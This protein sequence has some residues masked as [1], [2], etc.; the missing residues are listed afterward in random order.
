[1][2]NKSVLII[3]SAPNSINAKNWPKEKFDTIIVINNA[4]QIRS[5]WDYLIYPDDFPEER[6]PTSKR[7]N[8]KFIT[9]D[10]YVPIQN[11]YGGFVYAGGTMAFT[12]AYWALGQLKPKLIAFI[13]CDMIYE[14]GTNTHFYGIGAADPLRDD[15]SLQ[16]LEAKSNRFYYHAL[17]QGCLCFNLTD[18]PKSRLTYPKINI[19]DIEALSGQYHLK[20]LEDSKKN[21][22]IERVSELLKKETELGYFF[23]SG[24]YWEHLSQIS[25]ES[26]YELDQGWLD[27]N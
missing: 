7:F 25:K 20:T 4:W 13:G 10:E 9:S 27:L 15:V 8:Q 26:L 3:G 18:Q 14:S 11:Q 5:D 21:I 23:K 22:K 19:D 2:N 16:S 12:S 1:M 24:K 6:R 17:M